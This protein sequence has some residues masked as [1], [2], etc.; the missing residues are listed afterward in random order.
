M[1]TT[2]IEDFFNEELNPKGNGLNE[3]IIE[4]TTEQAK[5]LM[6]YKKDFN[7]KTIEINFIKNELENLGLNLCNKYLNLNDPY[8]KELIYYDTG[9]YLYK[10]L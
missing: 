9:L 2:S 1:S 3:K 5:E 4:K 10:N 7:I 8:N 6:K